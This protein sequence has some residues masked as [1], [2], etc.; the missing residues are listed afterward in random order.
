MKFK[1]NYKE[2]LYRD[3]ANRTAI[4]FDAKESALKEYKMQRGTFHAQLTSGLF[5]DAQVT[6]SRRAMWA[7][8]NSSRKFSFLFLSGRWEPRKKGHS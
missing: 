3:A 5:Y 6:H 8:N 1:M 2:K 7:G 4:W